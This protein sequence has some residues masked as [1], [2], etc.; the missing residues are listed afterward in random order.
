MLGTVRKTSL[1]SD[2]PNRTANHIFPRNVARLL[3]VGVVIMFFGCAEELE[4]SSDTPPAEV[5][6]N[7][8]QPS[9]EA[10]SPASPAPPPADP[11]S[12]PAEQE[13]TEPAAETQSP[14]ESESPTEQAPSPASP[15][16]RGVIGQTTA[17]VV[18]AKEWL[19]KPGIEPQNGNIEGVDPFSRT[20]SGYFTLAAQ[21][22]TL[23]L[24]QAVQ[25]YRALND[26]FPPYEEF[27]RMM[28]ENR[29][30]FTKLRWYEIYAYN[31]DT[32]KILVLVDTVAKENGP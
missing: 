14:A 16:N 19:Q 21:T 24:Q 1:A 30:E 17:Q 11:A 9:A 23:G 32:G 25:H 5:A 3:C 15:R 4:L 27:M 13:G 22:S 26:R 7:Q 8:A 10:T 28:Q 6:S 12:P 29:I 20:A 31:E 2:G 18:D